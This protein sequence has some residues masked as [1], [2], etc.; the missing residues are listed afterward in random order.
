MFE[1][2]TDIVTLKE[3]CMML[4]RSRNYVYGL[5]HRQEITAL[6]DRPGGTFRITKESI[7]GYIE[8]G[9]QIAV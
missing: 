3:A 8:K 9:K 6:R 5:I 1:E 7:I 4:R 2:Y